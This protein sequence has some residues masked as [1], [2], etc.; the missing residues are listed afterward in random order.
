[1]QSD[2]SPAG[3]KLKNS[4]FRFNYKIQTPYL[5]TKIHIANRKYNFWQT[6][7][8]SPPGHRVADNDTGTILSMSPSQA[9]NEDDDEDEGKLR[10]EHKLRVE[11]LNELAGNIEGK[12]FFESGGRERTLASYDGLPKILV[13]PSFKN[14]WFD[15][16]P[17]QSPDVIGYWPSNTKFPTGSSY[18]VPEIYKEKTPH[19]FQYKASDEALASYLD[20]SKMTDKHSN[21]ILD[22]SIF[23]KA[24][25]S[26]PKSHM[27]PTLDSFLKEELADNLITDEFIDATDTMLNKA[28]NLPS[29]NPDGLS[30]SEILESLVGML[31]NI[32]KIN[33]L[34]S[35]SNLRGRH[36]IMATITK[37][38]RSMR[39]EVLESHFG[40]SGSEHTK[41]VLRGTSFFNNYLFGPVPASLI[42]KCSRNRQNF[43]LKPKS[44]NMPSSSGGSGKRTSAS[45]G[46]GSQKRSTNPRGFQGPREAPQ[47][48]SGNQKYRGTYNKP[49]YTKPIP[50]Y[51]P[52]GPKQDKG[53]GNRK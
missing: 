45:Q 52:S 23:D 44:R 41:E 33:K 30:D 15:T 39:E 22:A 12:V 31:K 9:D 53:T 4:K 16:P 29:D 27:G 42:D 28:I 49:Q 40:G 7:P 38:K 34:S 51:N 8:G 46:G 3:C 17:G 5:I 35:A 1:M 36:S 2:A 24:S 48:Q 19:K 10:S 50:T 26:L 11:L 37:N 18:K 14:S 21:V 43:A 13:N 32:S 6:P 20:S 25:F 47:W